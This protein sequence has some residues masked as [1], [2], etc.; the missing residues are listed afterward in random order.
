MYS[1]IGMHGKR[2]I[3]CGKHITVTLEIS[4]MRG[5]ELSA[6]ACVHRYPAPKFM[7]AII[8]RP[9]LSFDL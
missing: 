7:A 2:D 5:G 8:Y 6:R 9:N 3:G 4:A 1:Y